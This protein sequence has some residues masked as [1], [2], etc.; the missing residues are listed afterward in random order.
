MGEDDE[1]SVKQPYPEAGR[2][3]NCAWLLFS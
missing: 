3:K 2:T 1:T